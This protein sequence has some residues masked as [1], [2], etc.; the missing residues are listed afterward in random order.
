MAAHVRYILRVIQAV[1]RAFDECAVALWIGVR[2]PAEE[3]FAGVMHVAVVVH[4]N[5][6]FTEHHL[7]H[8]PE[9]VHDFVSLPRVL[10]TNAYDN[11]IMKNA[12]RR[13]CH[14]HNFGEIH[15]ENGQE[16]FHAGRAHVEIFHG[17]DANDG[18]GVNRFLSMRDGGQ[19]KDRVIVDGRV[20]SGV[21]AERAL[22]S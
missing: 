17:R 10:F 21:V 7:A 2:E 15:F 4:H 18:G 12:F 11:E 1:A 14:I 5:D 22:G 13:K 8:A 3:D 19:M 6:V 20:K 16:N 9:A